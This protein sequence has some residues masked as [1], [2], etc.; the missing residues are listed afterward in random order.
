MTANKLWAYNLTPGGTNSIFEY[1]ISFN[2]WSISFNRTITYTIPA[3]GSAPKGLCAIN[4][5]TLVVGGVYSSTSAY[6]DIYSIYQLDTT[7]T[8]ASATKLFDL[9]A[10]FNVTGDILYLSSRNTFVIAYNNS[11]SDLRIGEFS[12]NG[13]VLHEV[14]NIPNYPTGLYLYNNN[15]YT[16]DSTGFVY[17]FDIVNY[18]Y[19]YKNTITNNL[20]IL[21]ADSICFS[22][23][24]FATTTT[25][26][27][28]SITT[29]TTTTLFII[30]I[31]C[32]TATSYSGGYSYPNSYSITLGTG[33]GE[34]DLIYN[35]QAVP[36]MMLIY[37]DNLLVINTG[38][39]GDASYDFG[40]SNRL[41]FKNS[42]NA[43]FDPLGPPRIISDPILGTVYL[44]A[45][46]PNF[47]LYP[48]DGYPR[49][50]GVGSGSSKF[51]KN[52]TT[53]TASAL[54]YS[55]LPGTA[56]G[57]QL[58]CPNPY[59]IGAFFGGGYI[60][61]ILQ[62][63]DTGYNPLYV[64]GLIVAPEDQSTGCTWWN[65][66]YIQCYCGN[67]GTDG[68]GYGVT[69]TSNIINYQGNTGSYAA[70]LCAD[71]RGGG[72]SDWFLPNLAEMNYVWT[73][74]TINGGSIPITNYAS[75]WLSNE[76]SSDYTQA[77]AQ[78]FGFATET[79][80]YSLD[81]NGLGTKYVTHYGPR[82]KLPKSVSS[83]G[84]NTPYNFWSI[85]WP[86]SCTHSSCIPAGSKWVY[87]T[88]YARACRYFTVLK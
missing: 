85:M 67:N 26:T 32:S 78:Y 82:Y 83:V 61:Y 34:V 54:I 44:T 70:K 74:C 71:Y 37:F 11:T 39:R 60:A 24:I 21:G 72:Y 35:M 68:Y 20:G 41:T 79:P 16:I 50:L 38:Y 9:Y 80:T 48:D 28:C 15:V 87:P 33:L 3:T 45:I 86:T 57:F 66:S 29:T 23:L 13:L 1:N 17:L 59:E 5:T 77:W 47:T 31:G 4:N 73:N 22:N 49:I 58:T 25:T 64:K 76:W 88:C 56:W 7:T 8:T 52:T 40:G 46:F 51:Y 6:G 12:T 65:G 19:I 2:P 30:T 84:S 27:T 10:G 62:P 81:L 36:D 63:G 43:K 14:L 69:N 75:Y 53:T 55:P 42:L 18:I